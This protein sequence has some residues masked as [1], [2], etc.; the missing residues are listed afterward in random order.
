[1]WRK[2]G[3]AVWRKLRGP[4]LMRPARRC[5]GV[6]EMRCGG[7]A[8]TADAAEKLML[9]CGKTAV[10][11]NFDA[12]VVDL[13]GLWRLAD[14]RAA[15]RAAPVSAFNCGQR[16]CD[17]R[18]SKQTV[19]MAGVIFGVKVSEAQCFRGFAAES[20]R[21]VAHGSTPK[22]GVWRRETAAE[23]G[24]WR[25]AQLAIGGNGA[26]GARGR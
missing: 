13:V 11:R 6:A 14:I 3:V 2:C 17:L 21:D 19:A 22:S 24:V 15:S 10:L 16:S 7:V 9:W 1:V 8:E 23:V 4:R 12:A 26:A 25:A 18:T 5:G 20:W